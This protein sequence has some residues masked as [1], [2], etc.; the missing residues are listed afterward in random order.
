MAA[1]EDPAPEP[2]AGPGLRAGTAAGRW[3]LAATVLGSGIAFLD[4]T[5]VNVAL[6]AI[7]EEF[8][9]S[10][11]GL[12]WT[13]NAYL[14]TLSA[15]LLLGGSLGDRYGR[16]AVFIAGLGLF[17][18]ASLLCGLA[19]TLPLLVLARTVQGVGGALLVPGS[20]SIISAS[21]HPDD[22]GRAIGAWSGLSG[23]SSAL[24]PFV[25]GWLIDSVSWRLVF[26]VNVP[27][28]AIA[29]WIA[30][31]HV[32]ETR[33]AA[34]ADG[35]GTDAAE[36]AAPI[37]V[38]GALL[39]TLGIGAVSYAAI[40]Q[41]STGIVA[42][43][44]GAIALVA[45]V[46]VESRQ[47][48]P[49]VPLSL[50]RIA[51]FTGANLT[52]FA[53]YAG[54]GGALFL[55]VLRLQVSLGYSALEAGAAMVPFTVLML[56]LSPT[57]GQLGRTLGAR[58][59][60]TVGPIVAGVGLLMMGG[61]APGDDYLGGVLPSVLV[62]G[63]G[64]SITVA[65][66]TAAVLGSVEERRVGV[67]SGINNAVARLAGLLAVAALPALAGIDTAESVAASLDSGFGT[68]LQICAALCVVGGLVAAA[69]MGD[70]RFEPAAVQPSTDHGCQDPGIFEAAVAGAGR[71]DEG[72]EREHPRRRRS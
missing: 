24:G 45:F 32:P 53:V 56:L 49:M 68:A 61:I 12:Q 1:S 64:M 17:T 19:P 58:L 20:L 35:D 66:L 2:P 67:A 63:L 62:F 25:G 6:P 8:D 14:V 38:P 7:G 13:V 36:V 40:E 50:F 15:L 33:A 5:V 46:W 72:R 22:R 3:V 27:L 18:A 48:A 21:F 4:G 23:V 70:T 26:L 59:P 54:L 41:G 10:M 44:L 42:G 39:A 37:D 69:T 28:A 52:T 43:V 29:V 55:V 9:A 30:W 65:P 47:R 16:R 71:G 11:A 51:Q 31:R 60:M 57:A 34:A